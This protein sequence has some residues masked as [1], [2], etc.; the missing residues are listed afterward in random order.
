[1]LGPLYILIINHSLKPVLQIFITS[2]GTTMPIDEKNLIEAQK[3]F[4]TSLFN[5]T[6]EYMDRENLSEQ[7]IEEMIN[8]C[9]ASAW[10]WSQLGDHASNRERWEQSFSIAH[11]QLAN[12]YY[13]AK[14][15]EAAMYHAKKSVEYC[16]K[17]GVG[18]F[19][20]AFAY[21]CLAKAYHLNGDY[22][23]RNKNLSLA[24]KA[25]DDIKEK[26]DREFFI[27]ELRKSP[28]YS[29]AVS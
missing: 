5:K 14:R 15:P 22:D 12:V 17:F 21:E 8:C 24:G 18:D 3:E 27:S 2:R 9:H 19:I 10:H 6:W 7:E 28:G 20:R 23:N 11:N 16:D 26:G 25:A 1:M 4:A 13:I 29:E